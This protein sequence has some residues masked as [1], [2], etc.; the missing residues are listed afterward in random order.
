MD[1]ALDRAQG[2]LDAELSL[3]QRWRYAPGVVTNL[4]AAWSE[5]RTVMMSLNNEYGCAP[6]CQIPDIR[7]R[8]AHLAT[9]V[10]EVI[11]C[12]KPDKWDY[13]TKGEAMAHIDPD[14]RPYHR[15]A[16]HLR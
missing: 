4:L 3:H 7:P 10:A 2:F 1:E 8:Y 16:G 5:L 11:A 13:E 14:L 12:L 15:G 6:G 9:L